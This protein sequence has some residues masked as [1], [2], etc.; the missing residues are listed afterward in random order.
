MIGR[1]ADYM[2][3]LSQHRIPDYEITRLS[4]SLSAGSLPTDVLDTIILGQDKVSG[5]HPDKFPWRKSAYDEIVYGLIEA[6]IDTQKVWDSASSYVNNRFNTKMPVACDSKG[7]KE[8]AVTVLL[9]QYALLKF[10]DID[11]LQKKR[12][13]EF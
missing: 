10:H 6:K 5:L 12:K 4:T 7:R 8:E 9:E 11:A 2:D 3:G 13:V 1:K